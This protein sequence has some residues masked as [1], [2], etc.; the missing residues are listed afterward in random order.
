M[1]A[2]CSL[3]FTGAPGSGAKFYNVGLAVDRF[4]NA[5]N[6]PFVNTLLS[7]HGLRNLCKD[8]RVQEK[9]KLRKI[10][11]LGYRSSFD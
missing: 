1:M 9:A 5:V 8:R 6:R 2:F 3:R 7:I 4:V 11:S 10:V